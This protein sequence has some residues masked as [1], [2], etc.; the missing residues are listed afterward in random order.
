ML[1]MTDVQWC[2]GLCSKTK[3]TQT[4]EDHPMKAKALSVCNRNLS[5]QGCSHNICWFLIAS[6]FSIVRVFLDMAR[7]VTCVSV[8]VLVERRN[9]VHIKPSGEEHMQNY[10]CW[11]VHFS[12][13]HRGNLSFSVC[14]LT[15]LFVEISTNRGDG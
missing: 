4:T 10:L 6:F 7:L 3:V 14:G 11:C 8:S 1:L 9:T 15:I 5:E 13:K 12:L 2:N